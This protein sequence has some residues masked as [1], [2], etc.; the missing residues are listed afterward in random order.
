MGIGVH[1]DRPHVQDVIH[2]LDGLDRPRIRF[3]GVGEYAGTPVEEVRHGRPRT[4]IFRTGHRMGRDVTAA[5]RMVMHCPDNLALGRTSVYDH[6]VRIAQIQYSRQHL[7]GRSYRNGYNYDVAPPDAFV[8]RH[9]LIRQ[10]HLSGGS[11]VHRVRFDTEDGAGIFP[12]FQVYR[13]GASDKAQ[14]DNSYSPCHYNRL[15]LRSASFSLSTLAHNEILTK[16]SP[17]FPNTKPGVMK[18]PAE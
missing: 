3:L 13:H 10:A 1:V 12:A 18:T 9:D 6:L 7:D 11:G 15:I 4:G 14:S 2:L 17:F 8:Q 5:H 16:S